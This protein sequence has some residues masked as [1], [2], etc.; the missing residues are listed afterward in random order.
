MDKELKNLH[1]GWWDKTFSKAPVNVDP[2]DV[3]NR[4]AMIIIEHLIQA[5][6]VAHTMQHWNVY[7]KWNKHFF[8]ENNEAPLSGRTEKDPSE[9][10]YMGEIGFLDIYI[11]S[12]V[13]LKDCDVFGVLSDEYLFMLSR[14][15]QNGLQKVRQLLCR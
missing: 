12:L 1:I 10:W 4:K 8:F 9:F 2:P 7:Q 5:S 15:K 14:I 11:I 6:D 3:V 13:K